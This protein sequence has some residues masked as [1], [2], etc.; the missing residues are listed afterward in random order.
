MNILVDTREKLPWQFEG[1]QCTV[2]RGALPAGDYSLSGHNTDI[3]IERKSGADLVRSLTHGRKR[4]LRMMERLTTVTWSAIFVEMEWSQL[5][6]Y[7]EAYTKTSPASLDGTMTAL[8]QRYPKT[9]W[10][11]RPSREAAEAAAYHALR[12]FWLDRQVGK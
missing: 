1:R 3:V 7:C 9:H 11:M 5:L 6:E 4:F 12:R 2:A 8:M 10:V